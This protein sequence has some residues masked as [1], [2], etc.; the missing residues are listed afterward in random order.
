[1]R[2]NDV[3]KWLHALL[4]LLPLVVIPVFMIYSHR[5][6]IDNYTVTR[7][8][9]VAVYE[10]VDDVEVLDHWDTQTVTYDDTDIG[11][12]VTYSLYNTVDNYFNLNKVF[13]FGEIKDYFDKNIFEGNMPLAVEV[14]WDIIV[15]EFVMDLLFLIYAL[16]MFFI[17]ACEHLIDSCF[18]R[19]KGGR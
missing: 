3:R 14:V 15:Y 10:I 6:T 19:S 1:M 16:F 7:Q 5:H 12:Q 13:N 4:D 8:E 9:N 2:K 17:D 18:T 11:A